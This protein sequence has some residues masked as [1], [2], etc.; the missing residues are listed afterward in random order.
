MGIASHRY[1]MNSLIPRSCRKA[2]ADKFEEIKEKIY[3]H[4]MIANGDRANG[5][6][7]FL[8]IRPQNSGFC[9]T[10]RNREEYQDWL[11]VDAVPCELFSGQFP[12]NREKYREFCIL[13][14]I[15]SAITLDFRVF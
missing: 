14:R 1:L 2:S 8:P 3:V 15:R 13:S 11:A 10:E 12:A 4:F 9:K 6:G 7:K 5:S